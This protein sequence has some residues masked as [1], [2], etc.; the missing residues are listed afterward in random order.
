MAHTIQAN[1]TDTGK[2]SF[3]ERMF[4][5]SEWICCVSSLY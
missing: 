2:G 4:G 5:I 3:T 1:T